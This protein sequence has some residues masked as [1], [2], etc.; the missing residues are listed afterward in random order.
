MQ[1]ALS[2]SPLEELDV[3]V[4]AVV[5]QPI[6]TLP[7]AA[8]SD[9][10]VALNRSLERLE[11]EL[12]RRL[13][14]F[15]QRRVA[16]ASGMSTV[17]WLR[18]ACRMTVRSAAHRIH[19]AQAFAA[20]PA[21]LDSARDG[22]APLC[23]AA[24]VARLAEDVGAEV[25]QPIEHLLVGAAEQFVPGKM[26]LLAEQSRQ[27]LDPDG[28]L[29][30]ANRAHERRWFSCDETYGGVFVLRGELDA[31]GGVLVKTAIDALMPPPAPGDERCASQRRADALVDLASQQL[32]AGDHRTVHASRPHLTLT[33]NLEAL[34]DEPSTSLAELAG[35]GPV[36][37]AIARRIACDAVRRDTTI[38]VQ[39]APRAGVV[40]LSVGRARRTVPPH[41][42]EALR[43]RDQGCRFPG[44]DRP[45]EWC[46]AHHIVHWAD[47][48][49]TQLGNLVSLCRR[50]H[51]VVHEE[52]WSISINDGA[53]TLTPPPKLR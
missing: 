16:A 13:Q 37:R 29:D 10:L 45:H 14:R 28:A 25:V 53:V 34:S 17:G 40:P 36:H 46:D 42:R 41:I 15:H 32:T 19:L 11:A 21:A 48:G 5:A 44:C 9:D 8:L 38:D 47:G 18:S 24:M 12:L 2:A 6:D 43:L 26:R 7:D 50:H 35:F 30:A 31:E 27:L 1:A 3:A 51:R 52:G 49:T 20:V 22:R 33:A 23:N 39:A 4:D